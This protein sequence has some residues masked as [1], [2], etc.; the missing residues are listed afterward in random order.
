MTYAFVLTLKTQYEFY[1]DF[2]KEIDGR[3]TVR[4][5]A[6]SQPPCLN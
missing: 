2:I 1:V 5:T 3:K 4:T 6:R